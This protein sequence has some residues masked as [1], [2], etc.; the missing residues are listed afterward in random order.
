M[1]WMLLGFFLMRLTSQ[2]RR[3]QSVRTCG[4]LVRHGHARKSGF[5][6]KLGYMEGGVQGYLR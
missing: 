5:T 1:R 4:C 3:E 2:M 6:N